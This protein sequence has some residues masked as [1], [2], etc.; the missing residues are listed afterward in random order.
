MGWRTAHFCDM[1]GAENTILEQQF[2]GD[3]KCD[4]LELCPVCLQTIENEGTVTECEISEDP[5]AVWDLNLFCYCPNCNNYIN[6]F[7]EHLWNSNGQFEI[8]TKEILTVKCYMCED[9]FNIKA[10]LNIMRKRNV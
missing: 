2:E 1:C 6:A 4:P 7:N 8:L 9:V 3:K 10:V 5:I